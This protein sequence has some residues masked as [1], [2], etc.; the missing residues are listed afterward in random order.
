MKKTLFVIVAVVLMVMMFS[1]AVT[2]AGERGKA[3]VVHGQFSEDQPIGDGDRTLGVHLEA[4]GFAVSYILA[5][6]ATEDSWKGYDLIYIGESVTSA[7]VSTKFQL[8]DTFVIC[9]EPGLFDEMLMGNYDTVY[10]SEPYTGNY[11]VVNDIIN[12]GLKTFKGFTTDDVVP[13]FLL[14]YAPGVKIIVENENKSPAVS[15][16]EKGA[17]LIDGSKAINARAQF[18]CRRQDQVSFTADTWKVFDALINY[19][20]PLPVTEEVVVADASAVDTASAPAVITSSPQTADMTIVM[21]LAV[22][23]SALSGIGIYKKRK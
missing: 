13:G 7:D 22:V 17:E 16:A 12:C 2:A 9:S 6:D 20:I 23:L 3:L 14:D 8:A 10:D 11:I 1:P 18:F 4:M 21:S 19:I 15:I 5:P